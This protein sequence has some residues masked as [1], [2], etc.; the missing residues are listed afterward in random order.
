MAQ[1]PRKKSELRDHAPTQPAAAWT[2]ETQTSL[3][4]GASAPPRR[5]GLSRPCPAAA[6][7]AAAQPANGELRAGILD[8]GSTAGSIAGGRT[9]VHTLCASRVVP[10]VV[11]LWNSGGSVEYRGRCPRERTSPKGSPGRMLVTFSPGVDQNENPTKSLR[12]LPYREQDGERNRLRNQP[13][14]KRQRKETR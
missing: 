6:S 12:A 14:R 1:I 5:A 4:G 7:P 10:E 13:S 8:P 11:V 9:S 3:G 2:L